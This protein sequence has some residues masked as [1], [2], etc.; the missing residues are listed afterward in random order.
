MP[1]TT[2]RDYYEV[3]GVGR[4]AGER[5][6]KSAYRKLALEFH[7]DR[8]PGDAEAE[9][10]FKE[11]AEAYSVLG[12]ADKRRRYDQ[13]GHAG[14]GGAGGGGFD[15]TVFS[16]FGDILGDLFGFGDVFGRR[17]SGPR[18]GAD[19]R[20]NLEI[21]LNDVLE[22]TEAQIQIPKMRPCETCD[23]SGARPGTS[24]ET[25]GRCRGSGQ[26]DLQQ[27]FF[28]ISRPCDACAGAGE[29]VHDRCRDCR[30]A[31]RIESEQTISVRVPPGVDD[32]T[33]LRLTGEGEAG[34]AGGPPGDLYVVISLKRHSM[35]ERDGGDIHCEVPVQFVQAALGAEVEIPALGGKLKLPIPAGCQSGKVMRLKGKGLPTLR[36]AVR[37]D[38]LVHVFVETP[39]KLTARQRELLEAFAEESD[40]SVS[41]VT[42]GFLDKLRDLFE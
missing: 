14:V 10:R 11:A 30:G 27:G 12:D 38:Q 37:G 29:I 40:T 31:G 16:D 33:R 35:F 18:R 22:A 13:F 36:S 41:P 34:V 3:L 28:R 17:S 23:G 7:P 20:Y 4:D 5:E 2:Q 6:I 24:A 9:G 21:E 42:K 15:P 25:C 39:T 26:V 8:N 19:L 1:S 32:G